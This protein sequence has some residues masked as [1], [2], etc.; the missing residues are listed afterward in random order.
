MYRTDNRAKARSTPRGVRPVT[1]NGSKTE[2]LSLKN[3]NIAASN[4]KRRNHPFFDNAYGLLN[5]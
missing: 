4:S 2:I 5:F 1:N 3:D